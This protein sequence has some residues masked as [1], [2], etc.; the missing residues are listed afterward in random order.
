MSDPKPSRPGYKDT[1]VGWIPATWGVKRLDTVSRQET[2][3]TPNQSRPEYWNGGRK[4][5]SLADSDRLD[6]LYLKDTQKKISDLG[7]KH[8]SARLLPKGTVILLRDAS[9]GRVTIISEEMAVSQHFV[10]WVCNEQLENRFL[11]YWLLADRR[12]FQRMAVG[13]TIVTIGL[14]FFA[15][16][17]IPI[18]P[19]RE[20]ETIATILA[21]CDKA[22][23]LLN[24]LADAKRR[25]KKSLQQQLLVGKKRLPGFK[26]L[27]RTVKLANI[28]QR[29][30]QVAENPGDYPV[31]SITAGTGFVS[32]ADKF[33]R[34][35]AGKQVANYIVLK[36]GEF[37]YNKG[38]SYRYPQ[39]CVYQLIEYEAGLVPDV[40]YSFKLNEALAHPEFIKQYF[41]A[42]LHNKSL[43]RWINSGVRN[44][45]LLNLSSAD[46]FKLPIEL[47]PLAEQAAIGSVLAAADSELRAL[48]QKL[49]AFNQQKKALMQKLLTGRVRVKA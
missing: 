19:I 22:I 13:T 6:N 38:N 15:K 45:G 46:F 35:I 34:V 39:G 14:P 1:K 41:L 48:S 11:Y 30:R 36:R 33:S 9:V 17:E 2:G 16:Y 44:N 49:T 5:V 47:P 8:S 21:T 10:A 3:H 20:Q 18:P 27:W 25:Q 29:Q 7:I 40:F 24:A 26:K 12:M 42:G 4:W 31:L 32:Q 28:C 37:A 43:Y 23:S